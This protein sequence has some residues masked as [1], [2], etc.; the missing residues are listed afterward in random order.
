MRNVEPA[1]QGTQRLGPQDGHGR[2]LE[3]E[4]GTEREPAAAG[5][6]DWCSG[7]PLV[8][9]GDSLVG[10]HPYLAQER[11]VREMT[12]LLLGCRTEVRGRLLEVVRGGAVV[13]VDDEPGCGA[14]RAPRCMAPVCDAAGRLPAFVVCH[15]ER[16]LFGLAHRAIVAHHGGER[17]RLSRLSLKNEEI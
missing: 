8:E 16:K 7:A 1:R 15:I 12:D 6:H 3:L 17:G 10:R 5:S 11:E 9:R 2:P 14:V 4:I 13:G